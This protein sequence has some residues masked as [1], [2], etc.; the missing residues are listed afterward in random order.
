MAE[1]NAADFEAQQLEMKAKEETAAAQREALDKRREGAIIN[2]RAQA[3][4]AASGAG[5]GT[6]APTIVKLMGKTAGEAEYNAGTSMYGGLSR[7]AG[8]R[9][10]AKGR[11]ASGKASLLGSVFSGFGSAASG[12]SKAYG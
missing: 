12:I 1:K 10:S 9:D 2:S 4:A 5:A 3:L 6:D 11:R 7:A 8:L